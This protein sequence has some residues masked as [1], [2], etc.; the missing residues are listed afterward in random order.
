MKSIWMDR[1]GSVASTTCAIHC[2]ICAFLPVVVTAVGFD[3]LFSP[4]TE[5]VFAITAIVFGVVAL[6]FGW[7]QHRS[8]QV[9]AL[10]I[11]GIVGLMVS[12]GLE[13][14]SEHHDHVG[15][16]SHH[17][18]HGDQPH[19]EVAEDAGSDHAEDGHVAGED[20]HSAHAGEHE[21][22]GE[23]EEAHAHA[24]HAGEHGEG[25]EAHDDFSHKA[26]GFVGVLGGLLLLVGH[27]LNMRA[28]RQCREECCP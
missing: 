24:A 7:R 25:E 12:R 17:G 3:F 11:I 23:A 9:A 19:H 20:A 18:H 22:H 13:M 21:E 26:G 1:F 27:L 10:M 8:K 16:E 2:A 15:A 6:Y 4:Q 14:G 5:W 28:V